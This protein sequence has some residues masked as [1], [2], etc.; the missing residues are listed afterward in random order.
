[1]PNGARTIDTFL[2]NLTRGSHRSRLAELA[3]VLIAVLDWTG[4]IYL[5][6]CLEVLDVKCRQ[7]KYQT[8]LCVGA[9]KGKL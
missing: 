6:W 8:V 9:H 1:V 2:E 3:N 4:L 7:F 5:P